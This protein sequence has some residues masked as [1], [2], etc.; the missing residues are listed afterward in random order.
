MEWEKICEN[1]M[2][3]EVLISPRYKELIQ[4]NSRKKQITKL[5]YG[6]RI[7][8]DIFFKDMQMAKGYVRRE[9]ST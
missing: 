8:I 7:L 6:Q 2:S 3:S 9:G 1:Y 5:K 4:L